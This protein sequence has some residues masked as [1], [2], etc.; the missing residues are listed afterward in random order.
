MILKRDVENKKLINFE[1]STYHYIPRSG[2]RVATTTPFVLSFQQR[3][4]KSIHMLV[5]I[6]HNIS[7]FI[8]KLFFRVSFT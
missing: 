6:S 3:I 7:L 5:L 1:V 8:K 4:N 2:V